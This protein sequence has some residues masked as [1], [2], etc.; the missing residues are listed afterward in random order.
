MGFEL[1]G[2]WPHGCSAST[3]STTRSWSLNTRRPITS[4]GAAR[5]F[6][7]R[8]SMSSRALHG[9]SSTTPAGFRRGRENPACAGL[10]SGATRSWLVR[11]A[12]AND[13]VPLIVVIAH[14][15]RRPGYW[16]TR[17][18]AGRTRRKPARR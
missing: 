2:R 16:L 17:T 7:T 11:R 5:R 4:A 18:A 3:C 8:F 6:A 15:K 12:T 9:A 13:D 14:A 10:C 1:D